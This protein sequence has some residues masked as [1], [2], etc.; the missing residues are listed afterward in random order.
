[1]G[2]SMVLSGLFLKWKLYTGKDDT[3]SEKTKFLKQEKIENENKR[4]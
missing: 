4:Y 2:V 1:M 3:N